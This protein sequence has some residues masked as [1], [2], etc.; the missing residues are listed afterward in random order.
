MYSLGFPRFLGETGGMRQRRHKASRAS[1]TV[2]VVDHN[3]S[4]RKV[5]RQFL[6]SRGYQVLDASDATGAERIVKLFVGPIHVLL[7][8][9][10]IPRMGGPALADGL[11]SLH[12]E[13]RVLFMSDRTQTELIK[14][15][16]LGIR[17]PFIRKPFDRVR[18]ALK[19]REMLANSR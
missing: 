13:I 5:T 9:V 3:D 16:Q 14:Q 17:V 15:G 6:E 7:V 2:L 1:E 11:R 19:V 10:E 8:E 4:V 12:P 18:L